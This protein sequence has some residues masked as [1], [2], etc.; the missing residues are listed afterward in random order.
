M[1]VR[2]GQIEA[3]LLQAQALEAQIGALLDDEP[4]E[5][6]DEAAEPCP[7]CGGRKF[8]DV[9]DLRV[10]AGCNANIRNGEVVDG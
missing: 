2:R 3:L 8:A 9:D 7:R 5:R 10:C 4:E 1:S 6:A